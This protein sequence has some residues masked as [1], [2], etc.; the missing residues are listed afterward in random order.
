MTDIDK[1]IYLINSAFTDKNRM[2]NLKKLS[3]VSTL[4][5]V[6]VLSIFGNNSARAASM[7]DEYITV[8][9]NVLIDFDENV[10]VGDNPLTG[11]PKLDNLWSSYGLKLD[12]SFKNDIGE[13]TSELWLFD[14][15]CK[16]GGGTS[17]NGFT[18]KC[19]GGDPDLATGKGKYG[20]IK[21]D[22]PTQGKVLIIQEND[23]KPDDYADR[24]NP[25]T[26]SFK[27]TD[28]KGVDF[29]N[30][31]LLDFD[32]PGQPLFKFTFFDGSTEEFQFGEDA[33]EKD[34]M[35]TLLSKDW[36]GKPLKGNNSLRQYNFDFSQNVKQLDIQLPG[37]G[38]VT[39]LDYQ[40]KLKRRVPEPGS[41]LGLVAVSGFVASSLKRKR[42]S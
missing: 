12:S 35:V 17:K 38:A 32:D 3:I 30:I 37:S 11:G 18:N 28:K 33:D 19:T 10:G 39:Y 14:S 29:N 34:P 23:G 27:F 1:K 20:D 4:A 8:H 24:S 40:R 21:Y 7:K 41:I 6:A 42:S 16:P 25:G 31:G 26:I 5:L 13:G 36:K 22:S 9:K 15:N 2:L